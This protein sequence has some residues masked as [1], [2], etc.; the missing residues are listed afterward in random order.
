MIRGVGAGPLRSGAVPLRVIIVHWNQPAACLD[1][2]A[3]F[4]DQEVPVR[5]TVV[6]NASEPSVL[7]ELRAGLD[8]YPPGQVELIETGTNAGFGPGANAGLRRSLGDPDEAGWRVKKDHG[9]FDQFTGATITPRA[10]VS[11]VLKTLIFYREHSAELIA[12]ASGGA[13]TTSNVPG[14]VPGNVTGNA[15]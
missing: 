8:A 1:T 9:V 5:V 7:S 12:D 11:R 10:V 15:P 3:R 13:T 4:M 2:V 14:N 6:D